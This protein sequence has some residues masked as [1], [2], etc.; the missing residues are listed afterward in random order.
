MAPP[1]NLSENITKLSFS[2]ARKPESVPPVYP[3]LEQPLLDQLQLEKEC[4]EVQDL[5]HKVTKKKR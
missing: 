3:Q 1:T 2:F 5:C 4:E